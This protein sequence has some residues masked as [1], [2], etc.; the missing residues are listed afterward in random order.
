[1]KTNRYLT[2]VIALLLHLHLSGILEAQVS[3][4]S[5]IK[6]YSSSV[7]KRN[8]DQP[9]QIGIVELRDCQY[10]TLE[11]S[12]EFPGNLIYNYRW[13]DLNEETHMIPFEFQEL[14]S[15]QQVKVSISHQGKQLFEESIQ[16][17][18]PKTWKIYDV[19]VSHHDLGYADYYHFMR[20]DVREM[21][22]E[23]AMDFA[24]KTD[25]WPEES[26]FHWT[27]ETSEPMIQFLSRQ[28]KEVLDELYDRIEKGQFALG[29][30][31][32][33]VMTEHMS[34]EAMARHFY[35]PN[36]YV[37]DWF[38][39]APSKTALNT[40]VVGFSRALALY[41][42]EADI[43]YFF[44]GRNSAIKEFDMAEDAAAFYWQAPDKDSRMTLFKIWHYYSPDRFV[45][46]DINEVAGISRRYE[47]H[48]NYPYDCI[49]A[50][51]SYDFGL[52]DFKNVE[53]IREWNESYSNPVLISGTFD[54]YFD[55]LNSQQDKE[56][57]KTFDK[58]APNAWADMDATDV[59]YAN[60]AR[61]LYSHLPAV[62]KWATISSAV[63][64]G[65]FPWIDIYQA[66]HGLIMWAEH[67]NGAY[68]E[69]PFY[70]PPS[71]DD[72]S[73]A[74]GTHYELEQEMHRDLIRESGDFTEK[75]EETALTDLR[76]QLTTESKNTLVVQNSLVRQRSGEVRFHLP[77]GKGLSE[78]VDNS[79]GKEVDFQIWED[80]DV[81]FFAGDVP[82]MGYKTYSLELNNDPIFIAAEAVSK[83]PVIDND[84]YQLQFDT[85]TG[86][87]SSLY[88]KKFERQLL[89]KDASYKLNEYYYERIN[90]GSYLDGATSY[91]PEKATFAILNG[92][93]AQMVISEVQAEGCK[94]II[95]KVTL[96][97]HS[98]RIDFEV[99]LDKSPSGR[100]LE[101]YKTY[102]AK[103]KEAI[104]YSLPLDIPDF[105]IR[106]ELAG[107][108]MEPIEDQFPGSS[109]DFYVIQNFSD[110]SNEEWGVT[111]AT[112]EPNMVEYGKPRPALWGTGDDFEKIMKKA[113]KSH[114]YLYLLNNMFFTNIRQSQPGPKLFRWSLR[115]H[116]HDWSDGKAYH[117]GREVAHPFTTFI[118]AGKN[119]GSLP[120][121]Q[122]SFVEMD[123]ENVICTAIKPAE[124]NGEGYIFRFVEVSGKETE[125][126]LTTGFLDRIERA[127]LTNL[128]EVDRDYSLEIIGDKSLKFIIPAF[129]LRTI[130]IVP[131][132]SLL[133]AIASLQGISTADRQVEL[134]WEAQGLGAAN[135]AYYQVYRGK[136]SGFKPG[137]KTYVDNT[138]ETGFM[139]HPELH[140]RGWQDNL[141]EPETPYHYRVIPVGK[142][143]RKG[144]PSDEITVT[145]LATTEKNLEPARVEGLLATLV[146]PVT[147]HN[148]V[149]LY[150]YTNVE[151]D[152]N[153]YNLYRS[154]E[155]GFVP[156][157]ASLIAELD[158]RKEIL[159]KTPHGFGEAT[160]M[161]KAYN[162]QIFVDEDVEP[163]TTYY[164]K[165]AAI[166]DAGQQGKFSR[167]VS[168]TTRI[169]ALFI[170][171]D[172]SFTD[173][174]EI[175]IVATLSPGSEIRYTLDG[176]LPGR[177]SN[178]YTGPITQEEDG[179]L[180]ASVFLE[181]KEKG[182][183]TASSAFKR[184]NDYEVKYL[185][186]HNEKWSGTGEHTLIDNF[187]GDYFASKFW[188]GWEAIDLEIVVDLKQETDIDSVSVGFLQSTGN[189]ILLPEYMEVSLSDDGVD[190]TK[191]GKAETPEDWKMMPLKKE[192]LTVSFPE[193]RTRYVRVYAKNVKHLPDWHMFGGSK[194]WV[195]VDEIVIH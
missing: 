52:P 17:N 91:H 72:H 28:S 163:Y 139:D 94:K 146:S 36:R 45:S 159:H 136:E 133:P 30:V 65:K 195:F 44:F 31:H 152:V 121:A 40:D 92:D 162:R 66:Y 170:K 3:L 11:G 79:T 16:F 43:P 156:N 27:V 191:V 9:L 77:E 55:D 62:E 138:E 83:G 46:Y 23:M 93:L 140:I 60:K 117:F 87:I 68:S 185:I 105:T 193:N 51:D 13:E 123:V 7:V 70:T 8:G 33:S 95:Q 184:R 69:G 114:F 25:H 118:A 181:G 148:Y 37:S 22:I 90:T 21:G 67:T 177:S 107:G 110:I 166:D 154:K 104:F 58:D 194:A 98:D 57:F 183:G 157:A 89:D 122:Y 192:A 135:V 64:A 108:V 149:G 168:V 180:T 1:M 6:V 2:H 128:V 182:L 99:F 38:G 124:Q 32:N 100:S 165:V 174:T 96:Y 113:D 127:N 75:A 81:L 39:T 71:L 18:P 190:F 103:G 119:K 132:K 10:S 164:Y 131:E 171:G 59:E 63:S 20:R 141:L 5:E 102:S 161:L 178:L 134:H 42:K 29:G 14:E 173:K 106:H 142:D 19:Q 188:Q 4:D 120:A 189:W 49:L 175:Q 74:A 112:V 151:E 145:T 143:S 26:R 85:Q 88:D 137:L 115:S 176:T 97:K 41:A 167:E 24:R 147:E 160:R 130:R 76:D 172:I 61:R 86:A 54:M 158:V 144:E 15:R 84:Y 47:D 155:K 53:G 78:L 35:T 186:P 187:R 116:S 179:I 80:G 169:G 101:D 125:V 82:S 73:A 56:S 50:E 34:Y 12:M 129:G 126:S 109:T 111:L 48:K 150:F 153:L